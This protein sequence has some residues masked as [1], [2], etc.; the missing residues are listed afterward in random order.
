MK[1]T[2]IHWIV[3]RA[4]GTELL[5]VIGA[6]SAAATALLLYL[7][8]KKGIKIDRKWTDRIKSLSKFME[9]YK[10]EDAPIDEPA[11]ESKE[12]KRPRFRKGRLKFLNRR[13]SNG[14]QSS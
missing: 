13:K 6:M 3:E 5:A 14:S 7:K 8:K 11:K 10:I 1:E 2:I 9:R 12:P 4:A